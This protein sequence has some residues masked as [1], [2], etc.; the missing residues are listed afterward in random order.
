MQ[1]S[2]IRLLEV[3]NIHAPEWRC[4]VLP[5]AL[6]R[7][8]QPFFLRK[9]QSE[10]S[11]LRENQMLEGTFVAPSRVLATLDTI[12]APSSARTLASMSRLAAA[13]IRSLS[14]S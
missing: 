4:E 13:W 7:R 12:T 14:R 3:V 9:V 11:V 2:E 1:T 6:A 10:T 8:S 5:V